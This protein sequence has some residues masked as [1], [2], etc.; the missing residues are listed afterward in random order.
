MTFL[1]PITGRR[2]PAGGDRTTSLPLSGGSDRLFDSAVEYA[3]DATQRAVLF[4]DTMRQA[5]NTFVEHEEAGCPPV[6]FFDW[7]MVVD[8][9]TCPAL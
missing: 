5:G 8:G 3:V 6:L 9:G 7:E 1:S 2:F 4:W